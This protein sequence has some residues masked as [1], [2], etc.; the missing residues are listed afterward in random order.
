MGGHAGIAKTLNRLKA[1]V[2]WA[3]M[4]KDVKKF[5]FTCTT[6]QQMKYVTKPQFGLLQPIPPLSSIWEDIAWISS[7]V[8]PAHQR[9]TVILV[10]VDRFPKRHFDSLPTH[11]TACKT[12]ELFSQMVFK[13]HGYPKSIISDRDPIFI[14][15]SW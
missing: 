11:F 6:C 14:S 8:L 9:Q 12:A 3:N 13:L 2:Y 15:K 5:V 4:R 1:N 10:V 7:R